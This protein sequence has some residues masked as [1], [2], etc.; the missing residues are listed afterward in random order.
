[1]RFAVVAVVAA[2]S[3]AACTTVAFQTSRPLFAP[4]ANV[5]AICE[6]YESVDAI[7]LCVA[8]RAQDGW[9]VAQTGTATT[10]FLFCSS[11]PI[12][13]FERPYSAGGSPAPVTTGCADESS[14]K[15]GEACV[16]PS[17]GAGPKR[18]EPQHAKSN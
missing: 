4:D 15:P 16:Y 2:L 11:S 18:C 1:M 13:C 14:C 5:T 3:L 9:R 10:C 12:V 7:S 17:S 6:T 8:H